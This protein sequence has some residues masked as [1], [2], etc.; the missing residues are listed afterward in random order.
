MKIDHSKDGPPCREMENLLQQV[1]D[2]SARGIKKYF[3][4][5]HAAHCSH[6][7]DFLKRL[8]ATISVL[9]DQK[10]NV[11]PTATMDRLR[12]QIRAM[13]TETPSSKLFTE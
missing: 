8:K 1:A 6:C 10:E 2:G 5:F 4:I 3:V 11:A 9:K 12:A 7:G 13:E